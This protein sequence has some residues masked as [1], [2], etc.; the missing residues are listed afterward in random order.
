MATIGAEEAGGIRSADRAL[1]LLDA[2][3]NSP[4]GLTAGELAERLGLSKATIYRLLSTLAE[5][6]YLVRTEAAR[7]IL[8][9]AVDDLGRAV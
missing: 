2:V 5:R 6:D 8:G 9:R 7:Y 1:R 4:G 3:G